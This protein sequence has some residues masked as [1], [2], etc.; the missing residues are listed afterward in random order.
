M[1]VYQ[2]LDLS[3]VAG[4]INNA[5]NTSNVR[6]WWQSRQ[7]NDSHNGFT[8]TAKYSIS[9]NGGAYVEHT[10]QYTLPQKATTTVLDTTIVVPH[11]DDGTANIWVKT[12]MDTGISVGVVELRKPLTL[13]T[14]PRASAI[15]SVAN[16]QLGDDCA[17]R[18]TPK[19]ASFY[20]KLKFSLGA[21]SYTTDAILPNKTSSYTH[22]EPIGV[23]VAEEIPNSPTGTMTVTLYTYSDSAATKQIGSAD[24][25]A[26][27]VTVPDSE[28]PEVTMSLSPVHSLPAAFDGLYIQGLSKVKATLDA[29]PQFNASIRSYAMTV[30]G[31]TYGGAIDNYTSEYL[32]NSGATTVSGHAVDSRG[33]SGYASQSITVLPYAN[34]KIL[35]VSAKRCDANGD[36]SDGGSYLKIAAKR[37]YHKVISGNV[38]KNFCQIRYRYKAE[39]QSYYSG[40]VTILAADNLSSDEVVTNPLL[41]GS[42]LGT[43]SYSVEVQAV[44]NIGNTATSVVMVPTDRVYWHRDGAN[45]AL[46]LGKYNEKQNA[47][48][49]AWDFYM[50]NH[51]I[52]GLKAP[53]NDTDAVT[54]GFLREYIETYLANLK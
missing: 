41:D 22:Y 24:S 29:E 43:V 42:L 19:S 2:T 46:G 30:G 12:W 16:I 26:F 40:W 39:N 34:P 8:K 54:L 36:L 51:T 25:K 44:D 17:V 6:I 50:N 18:W 4:S 31:K 9:I 20:Y 5:A 14:I 28:G 48:D 47:V 37:D 32:T 53:E 27:T 11:R 35:N 1:A 10:V 21:W 52:T 3:E 23:E 45:N 49:S 15:E 13:T 7:T 33:Y 38:Q